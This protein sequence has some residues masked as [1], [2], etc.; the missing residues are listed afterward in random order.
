MTKPVIQLKDVWKIYEKN[1]VPVV[2]LQG[3]N[4]EVNKGDFLAI[5]G[6]SG[7][8]KSTMMNIVGC[9]DIATRGAVYLDAHDVSLLDE[10]KLAEIRGKRIGF[11]FQ[12]FNLI[13]TLTALENVML[14]MEFQD[15]PY[16]II[17]RKAEHVL[18]L[19]GLKERMTHKPSEL[20]GGEQQRIAI[21]RSLVNDPEIILADEPTGNL[22]SKTGRYI[23]DFLC[24]LH[25][26]QNKTVVIITHDLYLAK[27]A[28]KVIQLKDGQIIKRK[29]R[30]GAD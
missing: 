2:A 4:L 25:K 15:L 12:Q 24:K 10:S 1:E 8:G 3:I 29:N 14:P 13:P 16:D 6:A 5:T 30:D 18:A 27:S 21:A 28:K 23:M 17:K 19:V 9:L 26:K 22:D 20:S 7:S 11:I